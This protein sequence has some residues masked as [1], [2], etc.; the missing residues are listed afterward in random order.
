VHLGRQHVLAIPGGFLLGTDEGEWGG[1]LTWISADGKRA[2]KLGNENVHGLALL[3]P[4]QVVVLEG[5]NHM[6][7]ETGHALWLRPSSG[8]WEIEAEQPLDAGPETFVVARDAIYVLTARSLVRI[9]HEKH[10][11]AIQPVATRG[12]YPNSMVADADGSLWV[13]MRQFVLRLAAQGRRYAESWF[14]H[15]GCERP[16]VGDGDCKC[17]K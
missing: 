4:N 14:V 15:K 2:R 8:A 3:G 10:A 7:L 1:D 6:G 13:G 17:Q 9:D 16:R 5:L 12:L 11:S